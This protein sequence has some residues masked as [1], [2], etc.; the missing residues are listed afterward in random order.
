MGEFQV[1]T[2][3]AAGKR[4]PAVAGL[5]NG[6]FVS[7]WSSANQDSSGLGVYGQRFDNNGTPVGEEFPINTTTAQ[8]QFEPSIAALNDGGFVVTW[9]S[10]GQDS[11]DFKTFRDSVEF[12]R[13]DSGKFMGMETVRV[14]SEL[15]DSAGVFAQ[16]YDADG[17]PVGTEFQV[18]TK[19]VC[20]QHHS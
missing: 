12:V 6:G 11:G 18:N 13:D 15:E 9:T 16:R 17:T 14:E 19:T 8:N 10:Y 3:P 1:N 2:D 20:H 7:V 4:E 5:K